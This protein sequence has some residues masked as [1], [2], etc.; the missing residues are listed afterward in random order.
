MGPTEGVRGRPGDEAM[1][2]PTADD[3]RKSERRRIEPERALPVQGAR[4]DTRGKR[5]PYK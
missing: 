3:R 1:L 5:G 2:L 4:S